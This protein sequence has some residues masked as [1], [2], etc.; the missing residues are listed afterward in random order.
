MLTKRS[1][2]ALSGRAAPLSPLWQATQ[3]EGPVA[4]QVEGA[5]GMSFSQYL[6]GYGQEDLA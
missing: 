3:Q 6:Y 2:V 4:E 1:V 5:F